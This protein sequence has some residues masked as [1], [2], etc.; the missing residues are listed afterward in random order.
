MVW[1]IAIVALSLIG[2]VIYT[3]ILNGRDAQKQGGKISVVASLSQYG[4]MA[5]IVGGDY[6]SV[7]NV[8]KKASVD[9]HDYEPTADIARIYQNAELIISNGGGYDEWSV[10]FAKA[11]NDAQQVNVGSLMGYHDGDNEHFW[12]S[13]SMPAKFVD[14]VAKKLSTLDPE[15]HAYYEAN[16]AA[17]KQKVATELTSKIAQVRALTVGKSILATEPVYDNTLDALGISVLVPAFAH[18][19]EEGEDPSSSTIRDW[20]TAIDGGKVAFIVNN[21]QTSSKLVTQAVDYAKEHHVPV[22]NV[23]E[24]MPDGKTYLGWQVAELN[25][26]QEVLQ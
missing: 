25:R 6:V 2:T 8:I 14:A 7:T 13:P 9:P 20:Q 10:R 22:V 3:G 21:S 12:Y 26:I 4:E 17:Y 5:Q 15:H 11:N 19:V 1:L 24:T 16:A 23:T 18:A